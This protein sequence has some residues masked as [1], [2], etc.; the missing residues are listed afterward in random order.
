MDY[1]EEFYNIVKRAA[2]IA[3]ATAI[4]NQPNV[5]LVNHCMDMDRPGVI[6]FST[7]R[8]SPKVAE[9]EMNHEISF[10]T[11]PAP[12]D[13]HIHARSKKA[14][15]QKSK[16]SIEEVKDLFIEQIPGFD[17]TLSAIGGF[18]DVYE[19]H[20]KEAS[21]VLGPMQTGEVRF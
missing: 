19:I 20:V 2:A 6:Y 9:F 11:V 3:V 17:K 21:V 8:T 14:T 15:V 13:G 18:L 1:T 5:R 4:E 7:N 10:S 12:A 16:F